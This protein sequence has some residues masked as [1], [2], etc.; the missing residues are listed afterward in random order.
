MPFSLAAA[1][2]AT[3]MVTPV[4]AA[5]TPDAAALER[6]VDRFNAARAAFDSA[7]LAETLASDYQEI[8]P[9]G[10]VDDRAK[11]LGFYAPDQRKP[12]PALQSSERL[13][14][15]HGAFGIETERLSF[16]MAR[17]DGT[18][19]TRALRVRYV[20]VR[21]GAGWKL[22]SAQYTPLPPAK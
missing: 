21:S 5:A 16:T 14:T 15:L 10:D 12:G 9:I 11:V 18:S 6:V 1:L 17:P 3:T 8:S 4:A 2:V 22:V 19:L 20:A 7:Q 13:T